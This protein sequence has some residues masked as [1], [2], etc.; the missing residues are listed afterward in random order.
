MWFCPKQNGWGNR[1]DEDE[2]D[3]PSDSGGVPLN[4]RGPLHSPKMSMP[5]HASA[6]RRFRFTSS[7]PVIF[8]HLTGW[9]GYGHPSH[10]MGCHGSPNILEKSIKLGLMTIPQVLMMA[11]WG[12]A[13]LY[14]A[15][16]REVHKQLVWPRPIPFQTTCFLGWTWDMPTAFGH[17]W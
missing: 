14:F 4:F 15:Y 16:W 7:V 6:A 3:E 10:V 11:Q 5:F 2:L 17:D 8:I 1:E 13:Y 9:M 12:N